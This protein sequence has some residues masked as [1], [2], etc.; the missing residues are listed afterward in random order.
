[1]SKPVAEKTITKPVSYLESRRN[2]LTA[3]TL[4]PVFTVLMCISAKISIPTPVIPV[5]LQI[6]AA[7]LSGLLL[8]ARLGFLSQ[9][10]YIFMGLMGLPVFSRGGGIGYIVTGSF[11]YI[12]GFAFCALAGG[13]LADRIDRK[14]QGSKVPYREILLIAGAALLVDYLIGILYLYFLSNFYTGYAGTKYSFLTTLVYGALPFIAKD[15]ALCVLASELTRRLW[16]FR[17]R[18][19]KKASKGKASDSSIPASAE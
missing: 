15:I 16:R 18:G 1:M 2:Q 12:I 9:A 17:F 3:I 5:T 13:F 11:G 19:M 7:I 8:G 14:Y 4:V 10:L 6:T